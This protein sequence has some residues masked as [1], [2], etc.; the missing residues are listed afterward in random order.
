MLLF[1]FQRQNTAPETVAYTPV[2]MLQSRS[3]CLTNMYVET[4][5]ISHLVARLMAMLASAHQ[6]MGHIGLKDKT[7]AVSACRTTHPPTLHPALPDSFYNTHK[8]K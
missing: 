6:Y 4:D 7:A 2:Y 1:G 8:Q 3:I 5:S